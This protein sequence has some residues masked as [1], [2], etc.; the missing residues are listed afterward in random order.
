[1]RQLLPSSSPSPAACHGTGANIPWQLTALHASTGRSVVHREAKLQC[2]IG[3]AA[4]R[5]LHV[6]VCVWIHGRL[7][8]C[9]RRLTSIMRL[10]VLLLRAFGLTSSGSSRV[11]THGQHGVSSPIT[12]GSVH[13]R[14]R[15]IAPHHHSLI[16]VLFRKVSSTLVPKR[17]T[18]PAVRSY[19][20]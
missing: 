12:V 6:A 16:V 3:A 10:R 17:I 20:S 2:R 5:S 8:A 11:H 13:M 15:L 1:M 14:T 19:T 7:Y 4:H 9:S 18:V